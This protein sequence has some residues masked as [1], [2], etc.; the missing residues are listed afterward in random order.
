MLAQH[1]LLRRKGEQAEASQIST[2]LINAGEEERAEGMEADTGAACLWVRYRLH[3]SFRR[4]LSHL[5]I[6]H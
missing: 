6:P 2:S 4:H 3:P 5:C 1:S